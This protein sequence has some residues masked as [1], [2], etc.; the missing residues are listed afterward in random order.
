MG[1]T[2]YIQGGGFAMVVTRLARWG[3]SQAVRLPKSVLEQ[4]GVALGDELEV[5]IQNGAISL[6]PLHTRTVTI[7]DFEAL[8]AGYQGLPPCED[9]F[10][11]ARGR[12]AL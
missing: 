4:F 9:G 3:N 1:Y 11:D 10:A 7:P 2:L 8:F 5:R 12:E 6:Q